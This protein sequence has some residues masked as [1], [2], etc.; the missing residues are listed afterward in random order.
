MS[1]ILP[2]EF[3]CVSR[4]AVFD[5]PEPVDFRHLAQVGVPDVLMEQLRTGRFLVTM[6]RAESTVSAHHSIGFTE[7][8]IK[9]PVRLGDRNYLY[10]VVTYVDHEYS[11]L[12][13]YLLGFNKR[14]TQPASD[15]DP[16]MLTLSGLDLD[17]REIPDSVAAVD[18]PPEQNDPLLLWTDYSVGENARS[19][20]FG[21]LEIAGYVS[22]GVRELRCA[23]VRQT[24]AGQDVAAR[25]LYEIEDAFTVT[26][27][28]HISPEV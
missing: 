9:I 28:N 16:L 13:G 22:K 2:N 23:R 10:P 7:T 18:L 14:L 6:S 4:T 19:R 24:V 27:T 17:L 25:R 1:I 21:T 26:G 5:E 12:R 3:T 8:L 11:L 15:A 20:G